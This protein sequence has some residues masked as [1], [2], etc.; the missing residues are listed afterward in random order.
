MDTTHGADGVCVAMDRLRE[1][2]SLDI[3]IRSDR[4]R[5]AFLYAGIQSSS[6]Q[7]KLFACADDLLQR[8]D[9]RWPNLYT[10]CMHNLMENGA[11][12][13]AVVTHA[14][15]AA[16]FLPDR[17]ILGMFFENFVLNPDIQMQK[18][19][20]SIYTSLPQHALYDRIIPAL[21]ESGQS[22]LAKCWRRTLLLYKDFPSS[23]SCGPF[24]TF[25]A[26]Y[27]TNT[28]FTSEERRI[29]D[30]ILEKSKPKRH[31]KGSTIRCK[32]APPKASPDRGIDL[33]ETPVQPHPE[34]N[35][36]VDGII[37]K[38]FAS[39]WTPVNFAMQ[40]AKNAGIQSIGFRAFQAL[41]LRA[42]NATEINELIQ[43][44][45]KLEISIPTGAYCIAIS[46]L[47]KQGL[48][49]LL[50]DLLQ[51]DIHPEEFDDEE[52]RQMILD[53]SM[54]RQD[55]RQER[56]M[57]GVINAIN[58][59]KRQSPQ[60]PPFQLATA[61]PAFPMEKLLF[62]E[63]WRMK[64]ALERVVSLGFRI[65]SIEASAILR[66][67]FAAFP[68]DSH[69]VAWNSAECIRILDE[70]IG[71]VRCIAAQNVAI[72]AEYW[73]MLLLGLGH[74]GRLD[75][76][77]QLSLEIADMYDHRLGGLFPVHKADLPKMTKLATAFLRRTE[78]S[79][80][81]PA[82]LSFSHHHHPLFK[83]FDGNFQR[84]TV[85]LGFDWA[86]GL[87]K[88]STL[89]PAG[90]NTVVA[91][92]NIAAGIRMLANLRDRGVF[93][94]LDLVE[95]AARNGIYFTHRMRRRDGDLRGRHWLTSM[96]MK[97]AIDAAWGSTLMPAAYIADVDKK[98]FRA[99]PAPKR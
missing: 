45:N 67:A 59:H 13:K 52:T 44:L 19:L 54:R 75:T 58:V 93:I 14:R 85:Q 31:K 6:N 63:P 95:S 7:Q 82:D 1:S 25:L 16:K 80:S 23:E 70:V 83:I 49:S 81:I 76:M 90:H 40:L 62:N 12:E 51:S 20:K 97:E 61:E 43:T 66:R 78:N 65:G 71:V 32:D 73:K 28:K 41:A 47:A 77:E 64:L 5:S 4:I 48:D 35:S 2:G 86:L 11:F 18:A 84:T 26:S 8:L 38:L 33:A 69:G 91:R 9:Y 55:T 89:K 37:E 29:I 3:I 36:L 99:L 87:A 24:L 39:S 72:R 46:E 53:N 88:G 42:A 30:L 79:G 34:T 60:P 15:L 96:Q 10:K 56:L 57:R 98:D 21:F 17:Y 68:I 27:Y 74:Q 50:S 94:D 92:F 22:N